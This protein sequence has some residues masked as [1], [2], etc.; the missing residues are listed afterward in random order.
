VPQP[1]RGRFF[2][3]YTTGNCCLSPLFF[4]TI[5]C[6]P[7]L[8]D[9]LCDRHR[10]TPLAGLLGTSGGR[11]CACPP[12][13]LAFVWGQSAF[14]PPKGLVLGLLIGVISIGA[15]PGVEPEAFASA[16]CECFLL[17]FLFRGEDII[18]SDRPGQP[19]SIDLFS[20]SRL[21]FFVF[22]GEMPSLH[23]R[24]MRAAQLFFN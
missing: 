9:S 12:F 24:R 4:S 14:F 20:F 11:V 2:F 18:F 21:S 17:E 1:S 8:V 6:P 15:S 23:F 10:A 3:P 5:P 22:F 16:T 7:R 13:R 19:Y